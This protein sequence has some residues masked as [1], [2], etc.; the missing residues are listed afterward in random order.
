MAITGIDIFNHPLI[1]ENT[2]KTVKCGAQCVD[3]RFNFEGRYFESALYQ[4]RKWDSE[5]FF[6]LVLAGMIFDACFL[7]CIYDEEW[8]GMCLKFPTL[9]TA[10][11]I[12]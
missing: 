4:L 2:L 11:F 7:L 6:L 1:R 3:F 12:L 8:C 10:V 5:W 9:S